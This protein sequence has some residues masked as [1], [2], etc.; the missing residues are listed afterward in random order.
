VGGFAQNAADAVG[1]FVA[2]IGKLGGAPGGIASALG[3]PH[4]AEGG[5]VPGPLGAPTLAVVHGGETV[6]PANR[7]A[8]YNLTINSQ[9]VA[10]GPDLMQALRAFEFLHGR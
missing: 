6:I 4:F 8:N 2:N 3:L 1:A 10:S 9:G 7:S 5:I